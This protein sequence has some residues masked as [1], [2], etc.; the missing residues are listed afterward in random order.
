[1]NQQIINTAAYKFVKLNDVEALREKIYA[2]LADCEI[3]GTI[4]L[5]PEGIN[6]MLAG[7]SQS[8]ETAREYLLSLEPFA[9]MNFKDTFS[10]EAPFER[11]RIKVKSEIVP[12]GVEGIEPGCYTGPTISAQELKRWLDEGKDF[13]L[14]DTRNDYEIELGTFE[15][16]VHWNIHNF[17]DFSAAADQVSEAD[18]QKPLVMFCTGGIRCEK[19][20]ALLLQKK[21]FKEVYQLDGGIIKYFQE[22]GGAHYRGDCFIFDFRTAI[23]PNC[24]ETGLT[25]CERCQQFVTREDQLLT[26]Y[27]R[28]DHCVHCLPKVA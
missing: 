22:V 25:Q 21:G 17:R 11:F 28:G 13:I 20:S 27:K 6:L 18:K 12:M 2:D 14:L 7:V 1:M 26:N 4:L 3:L 15:K 9:D 16:A 23:T 8:L 10:S 19:A 5:A 24:E